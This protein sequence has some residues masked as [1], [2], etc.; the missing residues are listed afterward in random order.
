[1]PPAPLLSAPR[2]RQ[3]GHQ[4]ASCLCHLLFIGCRELHSQGDQTPQEQHYREEGGGREGGGPRAAGCR[5]PGRA[6]PPLRT[7]GPRDAWGG[8]GLGPTHFQGVR[9]TWWPWRPRGGSA[10]CVLLASRSAKAGLRPLGGRGCGVEELGCL[11]LPATGWCGGRRGLAVTAPGAEARG[12][13]GP[14]LNPHSLAE[15]EKE[16]EKSEAKEDERPFLGPPVA[17]WWGQQRAAA[18][19][20]PSLGGGRR[21]GLLLPRHGDGS[22]AVAGVH[23][24]RDLGAG[25]GQHAV[26]GQ[27]AGQRRLVHVGGQAVAAVELAGDVAVVVLGA[28]R[29]SEARGGQTHAL[30]GRAGLRGSG[31]PAPP[32]AK[33]RP[34][35]PR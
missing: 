26:G 23:A 20:R 4:T 25:E 34:R 27:G 16:A 19:R 9:G 5:G 2:W 30:P 32:G 21:A 22:L 18:R 11:S 31:R 10:G 29:G 6:E 8:T 24:G 14:S 33:P 28:G 7:S 1:M 13:P 12:P 35:S 15:G 17:G 3:H